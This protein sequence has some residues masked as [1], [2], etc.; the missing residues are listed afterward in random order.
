MIALN[1]ETLREFAAGQWTRLRRQFD[2]LDALRQRLDYQTYVLAA[3]GLVASLLLGLGD[4]ATKGSIE[5]R[6]AEDLQATLGQVLPADLYD[7]DI[8]AHP[9]PFRS[10]VEDTGFERTEV[11]I[12][13]KNGEVTAVAFKMLAQGGYAGPLTLMLGLDRDGKILGV[14]V[15]SHAETPGLGD[16]VETAKSDWILKFTGRSLDDTPASGWRVKK[17]G[18][19][20]DQFAGAT[21]TPR[22][23]VKGVEGGLKFFASHRQ[24]LLAT[25]PEQASP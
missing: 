23:V 24:E 22:A 9:R 2:D 13:T 14:R 11:Y 20:F 17:D 12:A 6:Q 10:A 21:I 4:L 8:L 16:K 15:I 7:N 25:T 1:R 18:G 5:R 19:D 3:C